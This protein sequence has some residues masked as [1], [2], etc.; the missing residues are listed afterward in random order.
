MLGPSDP[1][2]ALIG[3]LPLNWF[4]ELELSE[5]MIP[6]SLVGVEIC[7]NAAAVMVLSRCIY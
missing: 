3:Q 6:L 2:Q 5:I 1:S 4:Y 7:A